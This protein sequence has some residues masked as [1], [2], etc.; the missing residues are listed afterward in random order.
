MESTLPKESRI[1]LVVDDETGFLA[2]VEA[3][4]ISAGFP[5][6]T[7]VSDSRQVMELVRENQFHVALLDLVMPFIG[8]L[9]IL[10]MIKEE[11]PWIE[12]IMTTAV[13]E[14]SSA[15]AA[16]RYGA[17]D[18]LVKPIDRERL[19]ITVDRALERLALKQSVSILEDTL[20][21]SEL[22]NPQAFRAVVTKDEEM[23][24]IF[25]Q[26]EAVAPT[27]YSVFI[28]GETG[29]GKELLAKIIHSLSYRSEEKF[30]PVNMAAFNKNLFEDEFF[31][32]VKG[33]F[34]GAQQERKGFLED[35][36]G[37]SIYLDEISELEP[38]LQGRLLRVIEE[39]ELYRLG[40][41]VNRSVNVRFIA[42]SNRDLDQEIRDGRFR[43]DLFHRLNSFRIHLHPLRERGKDIILLADHFLHIYAQEHRKRIGSIAPDLE[44]ALLSYSFPGNVRELKNIIAEA[45]ILERGPRLTLPSAKSLRRLSIPERLYREGPI[46]LADLER[47][48]ILKV[49][50]LTGGNRTHAARMLGID[51]KTLRRKLH[52]FNKEAIRPQ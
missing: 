11:S 9:E 45:V 6:P 46:N 27:D 7:L 19:I 21:F 32:H 4:L 42:S 10:K 16:M 20:A 51:I 28:T 31:G 48:H 18:Y 2:T 35:A 43:K 49:L 44:K 8:G 13:N 14:V 24:R 25:H 1:I 38:D 34:T 17:F 37:G 33:A 22:K 12:C 26:V 40:S 36:D 39:K 15:V 5:P 30:A 23:V 50:E 52:R 29:T 47:Q 41:P 3:T